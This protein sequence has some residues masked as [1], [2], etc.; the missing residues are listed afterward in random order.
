MNNNEREIQKIVL[1]GQTPEGNYILGVLVKRTYDIIPNQVCVRADKDNKLI[2]GDIHY[3]DPM[4]STV[5]F[6]AD[7]VPF[8]LATDVVLNGKIYAPEG[9]S[10]ESL[11]A[12]LFV[13][14]H[15]KDIVV[16]GDR[17]CHYQKNSVPVFSDP[18]PFT[19]IELRYENAYGG[20]DIYSDPDMQCLYPRNHLGRG[21]VIKNTKKTVDNLQLP[22]I[23][24]PL[25]LLTPERLCAEHFM[26]WERQPISEGFG[27]I[28]K[29][30]R[31][32]ALL[33]G[34]MPADR[35]VEQELRRIYSQAVPTEQQELYAQTELPDMDFHFFSGASQGMVLP[36]LKG[37]ERIGAVN[38]L[39]DGDLHFKLPGERPVIGLDI[40]MGIQEPEVFLHTVMIRLEERQIDLVWRVAVSYSGPDWLREM[41]KMEVLIS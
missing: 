29:L 41:K 20:I 11:V 8:K 27:W 9:N 21:F 19:T 26:N 25:D 16:T 6:E 1:P 17:F 10:V 4:N 24:A 12:S 15:R 34:V 18:K 23:E 2:A 28:S 30:W 32:R 35:P 37:D 22:N 39:P 13:G 36:F 38:L 31:P 33:A 5:E 3:G 14:N 40:G 7:F